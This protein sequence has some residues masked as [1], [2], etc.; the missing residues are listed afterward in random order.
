MR[1]LL[2]VAVLLLMGCGHPYCHP[3]RPQGQIEK[4][5]RECLY[6]TEKATG[7]MAMGGARGWNKA[8]IESQCMQ[9]KGY[10]MGSGGRCS[11]YE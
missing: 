11:G 9:A 4:A 2:W 3:G 6:E 8:Q 10:G 5:Y 1:K 7:S